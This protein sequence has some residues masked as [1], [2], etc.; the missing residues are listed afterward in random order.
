MHQKT[1]LDPSTRSAVDVLLFRNAF[2]I[3][4]LHSTQLDSSDK[5]LLHQ[6]PKKPNQIMVYQ[7]NLQMARRLTRRRVLTSTASCSSS[8]SSRR[9]VF[10]QLSTRTSNGG[11]FLH[12]RVRRQVQPL[13][14]LAPTSSESRML[15]TMTIQPFQSSSSSSILFTARV[16]EPMGH[17]NYVGYRRI[18]T[19][20]FSS[21]PPGKDSKQ[22]ATESSTEAAE[23]EA[24]PGV[25]GSTLRRV[26][27]LHPTD[28][29]SVIG[30]LMLIFGI[31]VT[32]SLAR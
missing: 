3:G 16:L 18:R 10:R 2:H 22:A 32:P 17:N 27:Q 15:G 24:P 31:I 21:E 8:S 1:D 19:Q 11:D 20:G 28:T 23:T 12:G 25:V 6:V 29:M 30:V 26:S 4:S 7:F 13:A 14:S 5:R 9:E